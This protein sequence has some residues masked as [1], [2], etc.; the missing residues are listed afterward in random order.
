LESGRGTFEGDGGP[1]ISTPRDLGETWRGLTAIALLFIIAVVAILLGIWDTATARGLAP[2]VFGAFVL[3]IGALAAAGV[4][5]LRRGLS[6]APWP[7]V[8]CGAVILAIG[9]VSSLVNFRE[10]FE[11]GFGSL[12]TGVFGTVAVAVG[13]FLLWEF[14]GPWRTLMPP[15]FLMPIG[16][17]PKSA[18]DNLRDTIG[19]LGFLGIAAAATAFWYSNIY[20]PASQLPAVNTSIVLATSRVGEH[21][22][23]HATVTLKNASAFRVR[24]FASYF[25][26]RLEDQGAPY[27]AAREACVLDASLRDE[28]LVGWPTWAATQGRLGKVVNAGTLLSNKYWLEPGEEFSTGFVTI[29]PDVRASPSIVRADVVVAL[30]RGDAVSTS[31]AWL[32]ADPSRT[33]DTTADMKAAGLSCMAG[34]GQAW[35]NV[36][37]VLWDVVPESQFNRFTRDPVQIQ[38]EW[39]M[40]ADGTLIADEWV[41]KDDTALKGRQWDRALQLFGIS[42]ALASE[43]IAVPGP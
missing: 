3:G 8:I 2:R 4:Y 43:E 6:W 5:A 27:D 18:L 14:V 11:Y 20:V 34:Q 33:G 9:V 40:L 30:A 28:P 26:L 13:S 10:H 12:R 19:L 25:N 36:G 39:L 41:V 42:A 17:P 31:S 16:A 37:V 15:S 38:T 35:S 7:G 29:L 1:P 22:E 23:I 32:P 24:T 21:V